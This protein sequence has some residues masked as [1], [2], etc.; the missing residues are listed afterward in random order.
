MNGTENNICVD[1]TPT[2]NGKGITWEKLGIEG[3]LDFQGLHIH[4]DLIPNG[5]T[6]TVGDTAFVFP[7][8]DSPGNDHISCEGQLLELDTVRCRQAAFLGFC[9]WGNYKGQ[10]IIRYADGM[11]EKKELAL[12]DW[13]QPQKAVTGFFHD[14]PAFTFL[15]CHQNEIKIDRVH[16]FYVDRIELDVTREIQSIELPD[17]PNMYLFALTLEGAEVL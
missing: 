17:N 1:L 4:G 15:Y 2:F 10:V 12:S 7:R 14:E 6:V 5:E 3:R 8:T 13:I 9:T 16:G 11:E